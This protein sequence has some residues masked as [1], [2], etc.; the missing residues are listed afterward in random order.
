MHL[1]DDPADDLPDGIVFLLLRQVHA[2]GVDAA[3]VA[4]RL[5]V[6]AGTCA[7]GSQEQGERF[8][9]LP[10]ATGP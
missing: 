2:G 6:N 5:G 1:E 8:G 4:E 3:L 7:Q 10:V 9:V